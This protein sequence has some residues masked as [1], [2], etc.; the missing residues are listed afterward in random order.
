VV[1]REFLNAAASA[2]DEVEASKE[3]EAKEVFVA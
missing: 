2:A 1:V 3:E